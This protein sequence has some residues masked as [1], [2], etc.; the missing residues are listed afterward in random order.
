MMKPFDNGTGSHHQ[1]RYEHNQQQRRQQKC[2]ACN[3]SRQKLASCLYSSSRVNRFLVLISFIF[4]LKT[5]YLLA[6]GKSIYITIIFLLFIFQMVI[7]SMFIKF[8]MFAYNFMLESMI[9]H[10]IN[11]AGWNAMDTPFCRLRLQ[12]CP[13][14]RLDRR[15]R[16]DMIHPDGRCLF[17]MRSTLHHPRRPSRGWGGHRD[18]H[19]RHFVCHQWH[20]Q[21]WLR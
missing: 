17:G 12:I 7:D 15:A 9:Y 19:Q 20:R 2:G 6:S 16:T 13:I 21:Y 5:N 3:K 18:R 14:M 4:L 10:H 1:H 8:V 11:P